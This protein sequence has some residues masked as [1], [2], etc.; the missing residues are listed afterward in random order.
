MTAGARQSLELDMPLT[1]PHRGGDYSAEVANLSRNVVIESADPDGV[2]GHTMYHRHSTGSISYAEFRH[3]GKEGVLGRYPVH[4]HLTGDTMRGSAIIGASIWDSKNRWIAIHG[5]RYL[6]V[7]DCIG[8]QSVGHGF[9]LEDG[10]EVFNVLDHNLAI[11]ALVG[12]PLPEQIFPSDLNDGAGFWWANSLNAFTR[13][14]AVECDQHGYRFEAEKTDTFDTVLSVPQPDGTLKEIDIRTIPFVRFDDNEVHCQRRFGL[15]LGGI[16]GLTYGQF[17]YRQDGD[18]ALSVG[19][20]S[21]GVGPDKSHP[22]MI[23]NFKAWDNHWAF[24]AL[25]P[26]VHVD[27]LDVFDCNYGLWRSTVDLHQFDNIS[28]RQIQSHAIFFPTGGAGPSIVVE[29]G[30]P[31]YPNSNPVDDL[32]PMTIVTATSETPDGGLLVRGTTV[33]NGEVTNVMVGTEP[34][35]ATRPN[36]AEWEI[37]LTAAQVTAGIF[38]AFGIDAAGNTE[39]RPHQFWPRNGDSSVPSEAAEPVSQS[40]HNHAQHHDHSMS[41]PTIHDSNV[42]KP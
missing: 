20:T 12:R 3:L 38:V 5:A 26:S 25:T 18:A 7:R 17:E 8:F 21:G 10:T 31:V 23:R 39:P 41:E 15:N 22:F 14:V 27:G 1:K 36:F 30:K 11:Q 40:G 24:H 42:K 35:T 33:D 32:P 34:V 29:N 19:G 2:R 37:R 6:V 28:F 13:N 16:R 9:F 4:F